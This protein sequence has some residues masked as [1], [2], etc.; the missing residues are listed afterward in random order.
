VDGKLD[1]NVCD[2][3]A[4]RSV[5]TVEASR[6][7]KIIIVTYH[8][9]ILRSLII[10]TASISEL[11][12]RLLPRCFHYRNALTTRFVG[13]LAARGANKCRLY[14]GN[15]SHASLQLSPRYLQRYSNLVG[16]GFTA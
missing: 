4:A 6:L 9:P 14:A 8:T 12:E 3:I 16:V 15:Q 13:C 2:R 10:T 1:L 11:T 5:G 7:H